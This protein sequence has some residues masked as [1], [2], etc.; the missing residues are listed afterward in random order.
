VITLMQDAGMA[1]CAGIF[2]SFRLQ[3]A[4]VALE[5]VDAALIPA[6]YMRTPK[7][8]ASEVDKIALKTALAQNDE[9]DPAAFGVKL[10]SKTSLIRK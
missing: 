7:T 6:C 10:T 1:T 5:I 4:P 3:N 8:P 2:H 9:L